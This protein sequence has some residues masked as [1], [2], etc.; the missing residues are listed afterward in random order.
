MLPSSQ[1]IYNYIKCRKFNRFTRHT[2]SNFKL[3]F[4]KLI[5]FLFLLLALHSVAMMYFEKLAFS[6]ALWLSLTTITT[7]GY[8]DFSATTFGGRLSTTILMYTLGISLLGILVAEYIEFRLN[9]LELKFS[10]QWRWHKMHDHILIINTPDHDTEEYLNKLITE[11]R[12]TPH[13]GELPIQ[14]LTRKYQEKLPKSIAQ[15]GVV[16]YTGLAQ[17]ND[18]LNAVNTSTAKYIIVLANES[19]NPVSDSATYDVLSRIKDIGT[20]ALILA[21]ATTDKNRPRLR[22]MGASVIVR[23]VRAYPELLIRAM[24]APG[25]EEVLE[26][27]FQYNN[28]HMAR[29]DVK[30]KN[31]KW[32]DIV[33]SFMAS[34]SGLPIAYINETGVNVN[35]LPDTT[36]SGTGL[37][38]LIKDSQQISNA[39]VKKCLEA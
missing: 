30:F 29:F 4:L 15:L 19:S 31:L 26:N 36:C 38:S 39:Q 28:D 23:P 17:D 24:I 14:I 25:T 35:P 34:N 18:N 10:G 37:I 22:S 16:H 27:M 11:I 3:Y 8:G 2:S 21:E 13:I 33:N 6:D 1:I 9:K 5:L 12:A 20:K 7:V 32:K